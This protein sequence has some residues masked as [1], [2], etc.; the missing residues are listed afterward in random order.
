MM[1]FNE[2]TPLP[3]GHF[4]AVICGG[5]PSLGVARILALDIFQGQVAGT[6][7]TCDFGPPTHPPMYFYSM[8]RCPQTGLYFALDTVNQQILVLTDGNQDLVGDSIF[9]TYANASW[10][11]FEALNGMRGVNLGY[12]LFGGFVVVVNHDEVHTPHQ[13]DPYTTYWCLPDMNG[14]R[15]ADLCV[16]A[17]G[18]EFLIFMPNIQVPLPVEGDQAVQLFAT[19][20][21]GIEVWR[22]DSLGQNLAE[23]LGSVQMTNGVDAEC[24]LSRVLQEG[25]FILPV[26]QATGARP[27]LA[28]RVGG[29]TDIDKLTA[30]L[31][32]QFA[33]L[34]PFPNPFNATTTIAYDL[35]KAGHISL[36]I[37]DL[38]GREVAVLKDGLVE[39]GTHRVVF[40]GSGLASGIYFA[41]LESDGL[42]QTRKLVLI[43]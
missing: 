11:G 34:A 10:S 35:P 39:A 12:H 43:K 36:R 9:S 42:A 33:L 30:P 4:M 19:W 38:L 3:A 5:E 24:P 18:W 8:A 13:I 7:V 37:Y 21:H 25:E 29:A 15:V 2:N 17:R 32:A 23:L 27:N 40:D 26:D 31:P 16:T 1:L 28:T 14:D 41:R 20:M 22:S 6:Y